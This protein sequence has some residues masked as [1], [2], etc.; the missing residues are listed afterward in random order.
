MVDKCQGKICPKGKICNPK[1]SYCVNINGLVGKQVLKNDKKKLSNPILI[2]NLDI[3][4]QQL[5]LHQLKPIF[6]TTKI[7]TVDEAFNYYQSN[8]SV[9]SKVSEKCLNLF[10]NAYKFKNAIEQFNLTEAYNPCNIKIVDNE[11]DH[12]V[13]MI[14]YM[15]PKILRQNR[16]KI[17]LFGDNLERKGYGGQ[18][19]IRDEP[20]AFGIATKKKHGK[21]ESS[22]FTDKDYDKAKIVIDTDIKKALSAG[23]TIVIPTKGIG[24]GLALLNKRAPKIY[25]LS[26]RRP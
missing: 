3:F 22:Y 8:N 6:H 24:T 26:W 2:N 10:I 17:Y 11:K 19:I 9:F 20:N 16:D 25:K 12:I 23:K 1:T 14:E 21:S 4:L 7:K 5:N 18:A 13:E 15:T